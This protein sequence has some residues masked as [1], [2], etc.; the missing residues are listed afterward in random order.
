VSVRKRLER[1]E[2]SAPRRTGQHANWSRTWER[3]FHAHENARREI[4]GL[5][6]LPELPY[7]KEDYDD[8]LNT[9]NTTIPSYRDN[10]GWTSEASRAFLDEWEREA[11][12]RVERHTDATLHQRNA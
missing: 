6:P 4:D 10:G 8:D 9:L 11:S 2:A 7:T 3:Y 5:E 1:L 12:K